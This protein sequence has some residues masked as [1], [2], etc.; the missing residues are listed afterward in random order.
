MMIIDILKFMFSGVINY[1]R[2][3]FKSW[4][5]M[6][7]K[8]EGFGDLVFMFIVGMIWSIWWGIIIPIFVIC[9]I[10]LLYTAI[11]KFPILGLIFGSMTAII[12]FILAKIRYDLYKEKTNSKYVDE[13]KIGR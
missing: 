11:A 2:D 3:E 7:E 13:K 9:V 1:F 10:C 4:K 6:V 5:K 12:V 8:S